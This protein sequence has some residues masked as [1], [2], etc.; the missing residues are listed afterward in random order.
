MRESP[1]PWAQKYALSKTAPSAVAPHVRHTK[2][3]LAL[4]FVKKQNKAPTNGRSINVKMY[5]IHLFYQ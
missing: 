1:A 4:S 5:V 3:F 2:K